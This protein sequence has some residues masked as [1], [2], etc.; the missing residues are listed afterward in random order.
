MANNPADIVN[1]ALDAVGVPFTIGEA[2]EGTEPAQV[3][4]RHYGQCLRQL[5][6]SAHWDFARVQ[7][8]MVMLGDV[9]GQTAG[10]G[11]LV[12][13]PWV[14]AY[15]YPIDCMK[16]RFVP[17]NYLN[18]NYVPPGNIST[19]VSVPQT[20]VPAQPPYG[21]GMRLVPAPFLITLTTD[22]PVDPK[23]NWLEVQG[24]SPGGR[25]IVC[26]N[27]NLA[28]LVYTKFMPYPSVW[29][30][31]FRAA[32]VAFLA[33]KLA[34]PMR[35]R[36]GKDDLAGGIRLR[37]QQFNLA[38]DAVRQARITNGNE[39]GWPQTTDRMASWS[40]ARWQGGAGPDVPWQ[41]GWGPWGAGGCGWDGSG[42]TSYRWD[43]SVF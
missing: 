21:Y 26:T 23:S 17:A 18:P 25:V 13:Q 3:A 12:P 11:T 29:D 32:L 37:D 5:L 15:A 6:R 8:S 19:P 22:Y 24:E 2:T 34:L 35:T 10:V 42:F 4:L 31:Q 9:T 38:K 7:D 28:Q 43:S 20:T 14:Y 30:S 36:M 1:E 16:A 40:R 33:S 39:A 41:G 27:I